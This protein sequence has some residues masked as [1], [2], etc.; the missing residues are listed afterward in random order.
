MREWVTEA[1]E[2]CCLNRTTGSAA[3]V[4]ESDIRMVSVERRSLTN[5]ELDFPASSVSRKKLV[6]PGEEDA[7]R[8]RPGSV[9]AMGHILA[10]MVLGNKSRRSHTPRAYEGICR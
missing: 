9:F 2:L 8:R 10:V 4:P 7:R 5:R 1:N 6:P 3:A